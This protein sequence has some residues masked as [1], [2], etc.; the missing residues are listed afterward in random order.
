M[1]K[2]E[3]DPESTMDSEE[4]AKKK[5]FYRQMEA[6]SMKE[7]NE[8]KEAEMVLWQRRQR[9]N[10]EQQRQEQR[11]RENLRQKIQKQLDHRKLEKEQEDERIF[12][13]ALNKEIMRQK[14]EQENLDE[15]LYQ[16]FQR[17]YGGEGNGF[18]DGTEGG[19]PNIVNT[20][21][22]TPPYQMASPAP[23]GAVPFPPGN[24]LVNPTSHAFGVHHDPFFN[25]NIGYHGI[26]SGGLHPMYQ[27]PQQ[28][29]NATNVALENYI[30]VVNEACA[31][32]FSVFYDTSHARRIME[33]TMTTTIQSQTRKKKKKSKAKRKIQ[34]EELNKTQSVSISSLLKM[35]PKNEKRD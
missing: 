6:L 23:L 5:E 14:Q 8:K 12:A 19:D 26:S 3:P 28:P 17:A 33:A 7:G 4:S 13:Y 9:R 24:Q 16:S 35:N 2:R 11:A 1:T 15:E 10:E 34:N 29:A 31:P 30:P 20:F 22:Y 18:R 25:V 21:V 32:K 27:P